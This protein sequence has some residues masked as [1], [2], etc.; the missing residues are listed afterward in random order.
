LSA[1]RGLLQVSGVVVDI[2]Q[3][4]ERLP[5]PG[6]EIRAE[7]ALVAA[8]G[9]FNALAAAKRAGADA[10]YGG[11][12]GVGPFAEIARAA[13]AAEDIPILQSRALACDQ[14]FCVVL[15]ESG[16]E[17]AY[18]YNAGA[19]RGA[20]AADLALLPAAE[21]A[22][23]LLGGYASPEPPERDIFAEWLDGLPRSV[24]LMFDPTPLALGLDR[25]RFGPALARADWVS[26][27][28]REA[29]ALTGQAD[30]AGAADALARGRAGAVVREGERGC[31]LAV[32]GAPARRVRGFPVEAVDT[33]GAGDAHIGAFI[34][35]LLAGRAPEE[36]ARFANAAAALS[37]TRLGAATAPRL[38]ETLAF[39]SQHGG[40]PP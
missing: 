34:A 27:N 30:P 37:V 19:E 40:L 10:A 1:R 6:E 38:A 2:L 23:A 28:R 8:G 4:V 20:T 9:G 24:K 36:A 39:L 13:L 21:F 22:F 11:A 12:L 32:E 25:S 5:R 3:K 17:R 15:V 31:W 18:V 33:T 7:A 29:E 14:G 16:G 35:A 26:A